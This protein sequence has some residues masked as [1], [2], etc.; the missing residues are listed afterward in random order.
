VRLVAGK[1]DGANWSAGIEIRLKAGAH[2]YW[3]SPGDSGVPPTFDFAGSANFKSAD[4]KFPA[5]R[6]MEEAGMQIFGYEGNVVFPVQITASDPERPVS[7]AV[8]FQYAACE[9]ICMP[10]EARLKLTLDPRNPGVAN[11]ALIEEFLQRVPRP[12]DAPGAPSL[13]LS[14]VAGEKKS[15]RVAITP[16]RGEQADLFAEAPDGWMF[17]TKRISPGLFELTLA[18]KPSDAQ[19]KLP[20]VTLTLVTSSGAFEGV[21]HLDG[22]GAT[23]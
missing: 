21:K 10:A 22:A 9:K 14:Q 3:R 7:V 12:L 6:R 4:V 16:A 13:K 5:P 20:P 11:V 8:H 18:E 23:P 2:T 1:Q 15:W 19:G 17:D